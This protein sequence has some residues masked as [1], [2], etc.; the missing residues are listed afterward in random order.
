MTPELLEQALDEIMT[1]LRERC[2]CGR[3]DCENNPPSRTDDWP[4]V[5]RRIQALIA[6]ERR[7]RLDLYIFIGRRV[8]EGKPEA[9]GIGTKV[10]DLFITEHVISLIIEQHLVALASGKEPCPATR[11]LEHI[12]REVRQQLGHLG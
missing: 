10:H 3:T 9:S 11:Y 7:R 1:A 2:A 8:R 12:E 4:Q 5:H 6:A